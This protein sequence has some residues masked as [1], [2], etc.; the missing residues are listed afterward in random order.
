MLAGHDQ[1]NPEATG[2]LSTEQTPS[3]TVKKSLLVAFTLGFWGFSASESVVSVQLLSVLGSSLETSSAGSST[4]FGGGFLKGVFSSSGSSSF[5][6]DGATAR[7][8]SNHG[9]R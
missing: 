5:F 7:L 9:D 1:F 6:G 4:F 8:V 3:Y 2:E